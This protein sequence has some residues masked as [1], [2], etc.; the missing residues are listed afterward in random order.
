MQK[1]LATTWEGEV[2]IYMGWV[3][4]TSPSLHLVSL[5]YLSF[6]DELILFSS[7]VAEL[8]SMLD[9]L[10][11]ENKKASLHVNWRK[12]KIMTNADMQKQILRSKHFLP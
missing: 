9:Q 5:T 3:L 4:D 8:Q 12:T 11:E 1:A 6:A 7:S 2:D 10:N